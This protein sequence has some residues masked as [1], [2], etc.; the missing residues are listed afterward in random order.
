VETDSEWLQPELVGLFNNNIYLV[1][2]GSQMI[3]RYPA[4]TGGVGAKQNW[5]GSGV[6]LSGTDY[7]RMAIDGQLWLLQSSGQVSRYTRGAPQSFSLSWTRS[8]IGT[9]TPS[10][11][12]DAE[13]DQVAILDS[14]NSRW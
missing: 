4:I 9:K 2:P 1:D 11:A 5:F 13:R 6:T 3:F 8:A 12:V 10:F 14:S 7:L